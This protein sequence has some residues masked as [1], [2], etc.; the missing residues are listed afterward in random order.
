L[1]PPRQLETLDGQPIPLLAAALI[2]A[3]GLYR[4]VNAT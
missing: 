1:Q 2:S 4:S 3:F